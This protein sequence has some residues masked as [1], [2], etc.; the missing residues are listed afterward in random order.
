MVA[1]YMTTRWPR[2]LRTSPI[3]SLSR[4]LWESNTQTPLPKTVDLS[5]AHCWLIFGFVSVPVFGLTATSAVNPP[6]GPPQ[7][8]RASRWGQAAR[9]VQ[10]GHRAAAPLPLQHGHEP[11]PGGPD[12]L[13]RLY[14]WLW[15]PA[16]AA[17]PALLPRVPRQVCRQVVEGKTWLLSVRHH[18]VSA[19][20]R[21]VNDDRMNI[22]VHWKYSTVLI[23]R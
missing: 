12:L 11:L 3:P 23:Y 4:S 15:E 13:R 10:G 20:N 6:P 1:T 2:L 7:S 9:T 17:R 21:A 14:V 5:G 22:K 18:K 16:A 19:D 8:G